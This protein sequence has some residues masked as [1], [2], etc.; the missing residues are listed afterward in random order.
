MEGIFVL[1][2]QYS[3]GDAARLFDEFHEI[4]FLKLKS[5]KTQDP[6]KNG[7]TKKSFSF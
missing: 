6:L 2:F 4:L 5:F 7:G 1:P 3:E